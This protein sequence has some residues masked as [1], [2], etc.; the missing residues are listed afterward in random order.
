[1]TI[2]IKDMDF[3]QKLALAFNI[4]FA[5]D[6]PSDIAEAWNSGTA[7]PFKISSETRMVMVIL[8]GLQSSLDFSAVMA[9]KAFPAFIV[10]LLERNDIYKKVV[11]DVDNIASCYFDDF[12]GVKAF[13]AQLEEAGVK[14]RS[15]HH[16]YIFTFEGKEEE[17]VFEGWLVRIDGDQ[18]YDSA[19]LH[20]GDIV[21]STPKKS[22]SILVGH[23][24][25]QMVV[26]SSTKKLPTQDS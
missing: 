6:F 23:S 9:E 21:T 15:Q 20:D 19:D 2:K 4:H 5:K 11:E 8:A 16:K 13:M 24:R 7:L 26:I 1:M 12:E 18:K 22:E 14:A 10:E 17:V 25:D 3:G